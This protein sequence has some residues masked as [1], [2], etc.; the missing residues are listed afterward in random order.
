MPQP[1]QQGRDQVRPDRAERTQF[2]GQ[3]SAPAELL[4]EGEQGVHRQRGDDRLDG[5]D[6][7]EAP[8]RR[9]GGDQ[10]G[11]RLGVH[12]RPVDQDVGDQVVDVEHQLPRTADAEDV[13][14]QPAGHDHPEHRHDDERSDEGGDA[15]Q[16]AADTGERLPDPQRSV[17]QPSH[18]DGGRCRCGHVEHGEDHLGEHRDAGRTE[19]ALADQVEPGGDQAGP[20]QRQAV[21]QRHPQPAD[22]FQRVE[23]PPSLGPAPAQ[24]R[25]IQPPRCI[26]LAA[27]NPESRTTRSACLPGATRPTSGSDR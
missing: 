4:A 8:H 2:V 26:T 23:H 17:V 14:G 21:E 19:V 7:G 1:P 24:S 3:P 16:L 6:P 5:R 13:A 27:V 25:E 18:Q 22:G 12:A 10:P 20:A 15:G 11:H 9:G